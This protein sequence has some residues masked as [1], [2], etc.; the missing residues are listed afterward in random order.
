MFIDANV[1]IRATLSG[2][3]EG[4]SCT[5][6]LRRIN[7]GEQNAVTSPLVLSEVLHIIKGLRG[8]E[9]AERAWNSIQRVNHL[10]ILPIDQKVMTYVISY[11]K[12]GLEP[13]DAFH[14]ATMKANGIDTIC[15]Y[16]KGFDRISGIK[17]KEPK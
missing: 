16:D 1:F 6:L 12:S 2:G 5:A 11:V 15:S 13:Q 10:S 3:K 17:R 14:A 8:L 7:S 4:Q 9:A